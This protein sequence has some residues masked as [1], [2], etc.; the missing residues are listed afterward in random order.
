[1]LFLIISFQ[2]LVFKGGDNTCSA[3]F[4]AGWGVRAYVTWFAISNF[5]IPFIFLIVCYGWICH[6]IWDNFNSKTD[7][8]GG[9]GAL[10]DTIKKVSSV[11][12][13]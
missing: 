10:R 11:L 12:T 1:M 6:V 4:E 2:V 8:K 5:F 13:R 7:N 9:G 3:D